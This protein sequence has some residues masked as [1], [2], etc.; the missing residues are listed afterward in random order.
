[1]IDTNSSPMYRVDVWVAKHGC[2]HPGQNQYTEEQAQ[3]RAKAMRKVG[4]KVKV[5]PIDAPTYTE[6]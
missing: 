2:Y 5:V 6:T 3:A 4:H 1:M